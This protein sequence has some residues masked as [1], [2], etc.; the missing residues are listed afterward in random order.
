MGQKVLQ[1]YSPYFNPLLKQC[2]TKVLSKNP[3][4]VH[5]DTKECKRRHLLRFEDVEPWLES[6]QQKFQS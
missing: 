5:A 4:K 1:M 3:Q 2:Q 6:S